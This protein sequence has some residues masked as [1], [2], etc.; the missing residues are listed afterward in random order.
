MIKLIGV[1]SGSGLG[2]R[3]EK[4]KCRRKIITWTAIHENSTG[5]GDSWKLF[6]RRTMYK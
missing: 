4:V 5:V 3:K 1:G 6:K 2:N